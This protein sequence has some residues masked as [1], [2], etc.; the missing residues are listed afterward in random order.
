M[1]STPSGNGYWLV[2][3]DGGIFAYGDAAFKGS[4]G[5]LVL[6]KPVVGMASTPSG[7]GYWLVA[8]DG[9]IFA[10]GDAAFFGSTGA[11]T[12]NKP[13]V[14]MASTSSG[15]GYWLVASDGGIFNY[16][17][18][19]FFGSTGAVTLNKPVVGIT[20]SPTG[21]GYN[22]VA[23]DGGIFSFGDA[24]FFGSAG[25]TRI[26]APIVGLSPSN[27]DGRRPLYIGWVA[28][29]GSGACPPSCEQLGENS[30]DGYIV[31]AKSTDM[32]QTWT[33]NRA[34]NVEGFI[35]P[36][37]TMFNGS[38]FPRLAT[39]PGGEVYLTFNQG[40]GVF[41]SNDCGTG[42]FPLGAPGAGGAIACPS[43]GPSGFK[44]A[45]HFM[46]WDMDPWFLRS[47]NGGATWGNLRQLNEPKQSGLAVAE[48][49]QTRHPEIVVAPNGRI[50]IA[51]ED[52]RHWYLNTSD[53]KG[54][55]TPAGS[56]LDNYACV[57]SHSNC[58]D[59]RLGD[60]YM[61]QSSDAGVTFG[62]N[63]RVN[64]RS[65]NNDVGSDYR[66]SAY[67]DYGPAIANMGNDQL[68]VADMD[69]RLGN[70]DNDSLDIF[71]RKV[72]MNAPSAIPS[73]NMV[74]GTAPD[75][76][77]ALSQRTQPGGGEGVHGT[78]FTSRPWTRPVIVNQD[79]VSSALVG[80][81]LARANVGPLLASPTGGLPANVKAQETPVGAFI[82]GDLTVM[83]AQI[84]TDL[85]A[86]GVP[87]AQIVR[88][89]GPTAA[90]TAAQVALNLDRRRASDKSPAALQP[91]PAFDAVIIANPTSASASAASALA[92]NRRLPI[93][94]SDQN[95]LPAV[96]LATMATLNVSKAIIVGSTGVISNRV[97]KAP[98]RT[99]ND[100]AVTAAS[101]T[102]TSASGAFT[103]GDV[104]RGISNAN[105]PAGTTITAVASATSVTLSANAT[106]AVTGGTFVIAARTVGLDSTSTRLGGADQYG[107]SNAVVTESLARGLPRN[108]VYVADGNRPMH[109]ALVGW[110]AGRMGGLLTLSVGGAAAPAE[111]TL[112]APPYNL[113]PYIDRIMTS[114]LTGTAVLAN[115]PADVT[116]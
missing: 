115:D 96:T 112:S 17:D 104:G 113:R 110:A 84:V 53:R 70:P 97:L 107:T 18:A 66:F 42:P 76:S 116:P 22:L 32:G 40:P 79:D 114:G 108:M 52:R 31:V 56:N 44:R 27:K 82:I 109:A 9:G 88:I 72:D 57:H 41:G 80:G 4:T 111:T 49:T 106:A 21:G 100:G 38:N 7:N 12:L 2:A 81:V 36:A 46:N 73:T 85:V 83:S 59:P 62:L 20:I 16:G 34:I 99:L 71:L 67:W 37:G 101:A 54:A 74:T 93:L 86:A 15:N 63:R 90:D 1:A 14:G 98:A 26:T 69:S 45:D 48:V 13:V 50:D 25:G 60:T 64:D 75:V 33:R 19:G 43:Y 11:I 5:A 23:S 29:K 55:V 105:I 92:V 28:P 3:S 51:W 94:Y 91:I 35:S 10:F 58:S 47:T 68:L 6:N 65:H 30:T 87:A 8:T 89:S 61:A 77:V 95:T 103:D 78:G 102:L 39:G 24:A